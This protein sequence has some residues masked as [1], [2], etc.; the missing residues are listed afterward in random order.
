MANTVN[1]Q[2]ILWKKAF[3]SSFKSRLI[4]VTVSLITIPFIILGI[5]ATG[6]GI[7]SIFNSDNI[8]TGIFIA[9]GLSLFGLGLLIHWAMNK[10]LARHLLSEEQA[11][12]QHD[13]SFYWKKG[14][15]EGRIPDNTRR[16]T[17]MLTTSAVA[18]NLLAWTCFIFT[19]NHPFS[20]A[21]KIPFLAG[22]LP[23]TALLLGYFALRKFR[24]YKRYGTTSF[25]PTTL[26]AYIGE[27]LTGYIEAPKPL[28]TDKDIKIKLRC[29]KAT[30]HGVGMHRTV[31]EK[32][33]WEGKQTVAGA[34]LQHH[35]NPSHIPILIHIPKHCQP[36]YEANYRNQIH[37]KLFVKAKV[38]GNVPYKAQFEIPVYEPKEMN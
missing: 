10:A 30:S 12:T 22:I 33:L 16:V 24:A 6:H 2:R 1:S 5:L 13:G 36:T 25:V 11:A 21:S 34:A 4:K 20:Y 17:F 19:L 27:D 26:P 9:V 14:W 38:P 29:L 37:W 7:L 18:W 32:L 8:P 3:G 31:K 28:N 15:T 35:Y 23:T